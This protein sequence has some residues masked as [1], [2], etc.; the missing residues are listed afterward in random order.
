MKTFGIFAAVAVLL[1]AGV[2]AFAMAKNEDIAA[3]E[4]AMATV[5]FTIENMTCA[6]CP[7]SVKNAM[8]RVDGVKTVLIDFESKTAEV[9]YDPALTTP[10]A[11]G[12]ASTDVGYPATAL[13]S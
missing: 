11:I 5:N 9:I 3:A 1:T 13:A 12:A 2:G 10:Q 4:A 7:I 6:T 8:M